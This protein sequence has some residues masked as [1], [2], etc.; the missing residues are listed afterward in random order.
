MQVTSITPFLIKPYKND[1]YKLRNNMPSFKAVPSSD[2][3]TKEILPTFNRL[4]LLNVAEYRSL[5]KAE[6]DGINRA[7]DNFIENKSY[8][9]Y[10]EKFFHTDNGHWFNYYHKTWDN[11]DEYLRLHDI[12]AS[13]IKEELDYNFGEGN[14]VVISIGRSLSSICKCLGYKIGEENVIQL[15]MSDAGR[16]IPYR[17]AKLKEGGINALKDYLDSKGMSKEAVETSGKKYIFTD[18]RAKGDSMRGAKTLFKSDRMFGN[19]DN[20]LFM[21]QYEILPHFDSV[22]SEIIDKV[23]NLKFKDLSVVTYCDNLF[24]TAKSVENPEDYD[25]LLK[26]FYFRFLDNEMKKTQELNP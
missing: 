19:S 18:F 26:S 17:V 12:A 2:V 15:P 23:A 5:S 14:Y 22:E 13:R 8:M 11:F 3:F 7:I 21:H 24:R 16:F 4:K 6:I 1:N 25:I 20:I 9:K 10:E